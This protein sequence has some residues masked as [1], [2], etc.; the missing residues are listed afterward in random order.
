MVR[1]LTGMPWEWFESPGLSTNYPM[2]N[3]SQNYFS[4]MYSYLSRWLDPFR[5]G[6]ENHSYIQRPS[7]CRGTETHGQEGHVKTEQRLELHCTSQRTLEVTRSLER[8]MERILSEPPKESNLPPLDFRLL[9]PWVVREQL[10]QATRFVT[11]CYSSPRKR[12]QIVFSI[13]R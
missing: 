8:L 9:A 4:S 2:S 12:V 6:W 13:S 3:S 1:A 11:I 7:C 5:K 10:N